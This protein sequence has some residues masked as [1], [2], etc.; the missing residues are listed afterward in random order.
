MLKRIWSI[1]FRWQPSVD[2]LV[3]LAA[4]FIVLGLSAAMLPFSASSWIAI[5]IR[6]VLM[7]FLVGIAFPIYYIR[8]IGCDWQ[9]FG[10]T[11]RK[12][13]IF[14]P[15][16]LVLTGLLLLLFLSDEPPTAGFA[17][18]LLIL[19]K[20]ALIMLAGVFETVFFYSFLRTIFY[21]AFGAVPAVFLAALV[22]SLHHIGFQP[23]YGKLIMVGLLYAIPFQIANSALIIFPFY[24][25]IGGLYDVLIQSK[26]VAPIY[27]PG[28]RSIYLSVFIVAMVIW[29]WKK[30]S[31]KT[32]EKH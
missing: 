30:G 13:Y 14:I 5:L 10:L 18:N 27:Y 9:E 4:G 20:S 2:T 32:G 8:R 19:Q 16:S 7:I 26:V 28:I 25:G 24:W 3:A 6:D 12:W 29:T 17:F 11:L 23:E 31:V 15:V 1:L 22:Y 21:R